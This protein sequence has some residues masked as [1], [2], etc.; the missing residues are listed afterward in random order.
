MSDERSSRLLSLAPQFGTLAVIL[1]VAA[2]FIPGV[3]RPRTA[4]PASP[5]DAL[6]ASNESPGPQEAFDK[7]LLEARLIEKAG[8]PLLHEFAD[9]VL[10]ATLPDPKGTDFG[11]WFDQNVE[12]ISR[13]MADA[14]GY[15]L[16]RYWFSWLETKHGVPGSRSNAE[17][18]GGVDR[19]NQHLGV[20]V[21]RKHSDPTKRR[22]VLIVRENALNGVHQDTMLAALE[23]LPQTPGRNRAVRILGPTFS[24]SLPSILDSIQAWC[25]RET[26]EV[27][28]ISGSAIGIK[29]HELNAASQLLGAARLTIRSTHA[30]IDVQMNAMLHYLANP[31]NTQPTDDFMPKEGKHSELDL[32]HVAFLVES[33]SGFGTAAVAATKTATSLDGEQVHEPWVLRFPLHISKLTA[34]LSSEQRERDERLGLGSRGTLNALDEARGKRDLIPASDELRTAELNKRLL[35]DYCTILRR[36]RVR[37]IGILATDPRDKLYLFDL[38]QRRGGNARLFTHGADNHFVH[39]AYFR[40]MRGVLIVSTFSLLPQSQQ[41]TNVWRSEGET[42]RLPFPSTYS[43]GLY[44]AVLAQLGED[45]KMLDYRPPAFEHHHGAPIVQ[46]PLWITTVGERGQFVP[47]AYF[48]NEKVPEEGKEKL[49][50]RWGESSALTYELPKEVVQVEIEEKQRRLERNQS[51]VA[52]YAP[53][54]LTELSFAMA[55]VLVVAGFALRAIVRSYPDLRRA[56]L[57]PYRPMGLRDWYTALVGIGLML[58]AT[59]FAIYFHTLHH[60]GH[61]DYFLLSGR[62]PVIGILFVLVIGMG[63][64]APL[65]LIFTVLPLLSWVVNRLDDKPD[66]VPVP[67]SKLP[68]W[69]LALSV[70]VALLTFLI[71]LGLCLRVYGQGHPQPGQM[72]FLERAADLYGGTS[73]VL[74]CLLIALGLVGFA[75]MGFWLLDL[76]LRFRVESPYPSVEDLLPPK[77]DPT[78]LALR[79]IRTGSEAIDHNLWQTSIMRKKWMVYVIAG[80]GGLAFAVPSYLNAHRTWDGPFWDRIFLVGFSVLAAFS[81]VSAFRFI[82][83]WRYVKLILRGMA[84]V[85]MVGAFDRLPER[86][87]AMLARFLLVGRRRSS[88]LAVPYRLLAELRNSTS[89]A[90]RIAIDD[91]LMLSPDAANGDP[92]IPGRQAS[93]LSLAAR[94]LVLA[95][96]PAWNKKNVC[97]AY[98]SQPTSKDEPA[99]GPQA[100]AE[101]F[102]AVQAVFFV[103]QYFTQLRY[104]AYMGTFAAGCLLFALTDYHFEPESLVMLS[105]AGLVA[106]VVSVV[107]W[108]L[109][110]INKNEIVSRVTRTTPGRFSLDSGPLMMNAIRLA[111]PLLIIVMVQLSGRMRSVVEPVF[112]LFR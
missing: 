34:I 72:L 86:T 40:P 90:C 19:N 18:K 22:V 85:P 74:P 50:W 110:Q 58:A 57:D 24:G 55:F 36:E 62:Y 3:T 12:G 76:R 26:A 89:G 69:R 45:R 106:T 108:G 23:L 31:G 10:I 13:A 73:A 78:G 68:R 100:L 107:V 9:R 56:L 52:T 61:F 82:M 5:P 59:P 70:S 65:L 1:A 112:G 15:G 105:G 98:G 96:L 43:Q 38:L 21:F 71:S 77:T 102:I 30:P 14:D 63:L 20:L 60:Y 75:I 54:H 81:A 80:A 49:V 32:R 109:V 66:P 64:A 2:A 6:V 111:G 87:S 53:P 7:F 33:N 93:K 37:Y 104:F 67:C 101:Q 28:I 42:R 4:S 16:E 84:G 48:V 83:L 94:E 41:W 44:N 88:D 27:T 103:S 8:A 46:P 29:P 99:Q 51:D 35:E 25:C 11:Y 17:P 39:P 79:R 97:E 47:L 95:L 91:A 92:D